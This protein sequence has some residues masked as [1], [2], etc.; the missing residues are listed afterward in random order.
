MVGI[1]HKLG[2]LFDGSGGFLLE[3]MQKIGFTLVDGRVVGCLDENNEPITTRGIWR[4]G[5]ENRAIS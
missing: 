1:K 5:N 4:T 3:E 2:S